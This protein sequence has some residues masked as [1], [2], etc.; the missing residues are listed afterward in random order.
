MLSQ[1]IHKHMLLFSLDYKQLKY[2]QE[3][4]PQKKS[5][6]ISILR[7]RIRRF[8]IRLFDP[9]PAIINLNKLVI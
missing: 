1:S 5:R 9:I 4:M 7:R 2:S 6:I 3:L 8:R